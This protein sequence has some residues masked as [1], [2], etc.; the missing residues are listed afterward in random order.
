MRLRADGATTVIDVRSKSRVGRATW[1]PTRSG[2]RRS[3]RSSRPGRSEP[4]ERG[5]LR[6]A[7]V[8][9]AARRAHDLVDEDEE[10]GKLVAGDVRARRLAEL[11]F[12]GPL[13]LAQLDQRRHLL[14]P[15]VVRRAHHHG[16]VH[17]RV[18]LE[19]VLDLLGE[20]LLSARVDRDR[21]AP[22]QAQ[23]ALL[24]EAG[25]VARDRVAHAVHHRER[26]RGLRLVLVVAERHGAAA[27]QPA[28]LG[29]AGLEQ[30]REV[31][32]QHH[33]AG[34]ER[35]VSRAG[36]TPGHAELHRLRA[37]LGGAQRVED[38]HLGEQLEELLLE[39]R[40]QDGSARGEQLEGGE[41][42]AAL[43][44]LIRERPAEGIA[45][46]RERVDLLAL[47]RRPDVVRVEVARL[48][49]HHDRAADV[50]HVEGH[51]VRRAVH[52][53]RSRERPD[54]ARL[55]ALDDLLERAGIAGVERGAQDVF[56]P[57]EHAL[58][59]AGGAARVE[60][61]EVVGREV[62]AGRPGLGRGE[63]LLVVEGSGQERLAR[64]VL[65]LEPEPH[66]REAA[67]DAREDRREARVEDDR[68]RVGV[69]EE[70]LEL[71]VDVA[72]VHV[73]GDAARLERAD[74]PLEIL[75]SVVEIE[76]D[77]RLPG[78]PVAQLAARRAAAQP[79]APQHAREPPRAIREL[80]PAE[81]A[82]AE[83]QALALRDRR[84][85]RLVDRGQVEHRA[86]S[87]EGEP[88]LP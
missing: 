55:R 79:R 49:L 6:P 12:G 39:R 11:G 23:Q 31:G 62:G 25:A 19:G 30:P 9:L 67:A 61:V 71:L 37:A 8:G 56:L 69:V 16:V 50:P 85:D 1:A 44:Q 4:R 72:V 22:E 38:A 43:A 3:G 77:V 65:H 83:D 21:V 78:L 53:G 29:G 27:G 32:L 13:A 66:L 18:M 74:H 57:P 42:V 45:H 87:E 86:V 52:E 76:R 28:L 5:G 73:Q 75:V 7:V 82:V 64:A 48:A 84:G 26:L 47:D 46:D 51:P 63:R 2:S 41:I 20:D 34:R 88:R 54:P 10:L 36:A 17:R 35:E 14:A 58:G 59:H 33:V 70:V 24:V 40:G 68:A 15:A 80:R 60:H 81:P